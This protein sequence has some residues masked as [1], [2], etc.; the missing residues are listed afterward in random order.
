LLVSDPQFRVS[1]WVNARVLAVALEVRQKIVILGRK[2]TKPLAGSKAR[3]LESKT[4][5]SAVKRLRGGA[6]ED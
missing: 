3:R 2:A 4:R 5:R 1:R 6:I